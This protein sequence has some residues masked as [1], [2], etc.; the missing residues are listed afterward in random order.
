MAKY[1][2]RNISIVIYSSA[3]SK[4]IHDLHIKCEVI[5]TISTTPSIANVTVYNLAQDSL[6]FLTSIYD[7]DGKSQYKAIINLDNKEVFKGDL[8]NVRSIFK[9]GTWTTSIYLADGYNILRKKAK[10]ES[11]KGDTRSSIT[12]QLMDTLS[13]VGLS[14]FDLQAMKNK[15]GD[16]SILKRVLYDGNVVENI[17]KLIKDCLPESDVYVESDKIHLVNKGS[18]KDEIINLK[19]FLEPPELN[20]AGCRAIM[21]LRTDIKIASQ[22][23]LQA[24]SYNQAFGNLSTNRPQKSRFLGEGTY[25]VTEV[26]NEFDNFS[27]SVAK[28][29]VTGIYLR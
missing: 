1:S 14:G 15:C 11:K 17:K 25:K 24:K 18:A 26:F 4:V 6:S 22:I 20:E 2:T 23:T 16:K 12:N 29:K 21:L 8:V 27:A 28:T 9:Q 7:A 10:V 5:K 19:S 13:D 3:K